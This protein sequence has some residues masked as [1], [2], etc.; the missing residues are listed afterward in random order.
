LP[1]A[2]A[3]YEQVRDAQV[4]KLGA[5]HPSTLITLDNLSKAYKAAGRLPDA[6]AL[7]EQVRD[8]RVKKLGADHPSTLV[9]LSN[10]ARAYRAA[11][12]L[13]L[14]IALFEQ[15][16]DARVKKLGADHPDTLVTL[17]NLAGA[18]KAAGRLPEAT[19]LYEQVRDGQVKKL[20]ADHPDALTTLNNLAGA[21]KAA[22]RLPDAIPLYEQAATGVAKRQF[23]H[24][25]AGRIIGN[26]A[27]AYEEA[28]QFDKAEGWRRQWL[29]VVKERSGA[30]SPAYA[31]QLA[32]LGPNLLRQKKWTD[33]ESVLRE[34]LAIREKTQPDAWTRFNTMSALGEALAGQ[35]KYDEAK[36][37]LLKGY[38]G[39]KQ[40]EKTIPKTG[41]AELR[42]P[43]AID[44]L[45]D[46]YT[47]LNK[48]DEAAKWRAERARYPG[49]REPKK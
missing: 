27:A 47:A 43:E 31:G 21:Y 9:T 44:R 13:P 3:L 41:G 30:D 11:D 28:G 25:Y 2:I 16:R 34:C 29:A 6:I 10:L 33:A 35:E 24:E 1:E 46:F 14:V 48:P 15:V 49:I 42:I 23:Q 37:L 12:R 7:F 8:A 18:Y 17:N 36:P 20:E 19:R 4:K 40:R 26:T 39:M 5:D 22:G 38:E 45:I 32:A